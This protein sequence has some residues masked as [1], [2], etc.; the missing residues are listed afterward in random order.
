MKVSGTVSKAATIASKLATVVRNVVNAVGNF[1]GWNTLHFRSVRTNISPSCPVITLEGPLVTLGVVHADVVGNHQVMVGW[2]TLAEFGNAGF[3]VYRAPKEADGQCSNFTKVNNALIP[4]QVNGVGNHS[5][6]YEDQTPGSGKGY[7]YSIESVDTEG[8]AVLF[9][10]MVVKAT[11]PTLVTLG[12]FT[13]TDSIRLQWETMSEEDTAGFNLWRAKAPA[14]G[15]CTSQRVEDYTEVTK[16]NP[17]L[18]ANS[19][20]FLQGASYSYQDRQVAAQTTYCYGLEEI[21]GEGMSTFYWGWLIS[22][23]AH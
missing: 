9:E 6:A 21:N 16:L 5:Y 14:D 15:K 1:F 18:I 13:A 2:Q 3:N 23:M 11:G 8:T 12:D 17:Q 10:N 19:G 20:A 4:S 22:A 7:C